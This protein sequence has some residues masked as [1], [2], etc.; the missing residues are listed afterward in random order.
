LA[1]GDPPPL[2]FILVLV[3]G[4]AK[5]C[6]D[7]KAV[8]GAKVI[9]FSKKNHNLKVETTTNQEGKF[10]ATAILFGAHAQAA[11]ADLTADF[12]GFTIGNFQ[13]FVVT[14]PFIGAFIQLNVCL[15]PAKCACTRLAVAVDPPEV[16]AVGDI[17][18][19][20]DRVKV[21]YFINLPY[22]VT[23][24]CA[25]APGSCSGKINVTVTVVVTQ[26]PSSPVAKI[27]TFSRTC[28]GRCPGGGT[29]RGGVG[30]PFFV[31]GRRE[32]PQG[33][34]RVLPFTVAIT[35]VFTP[36]GCPGA[37]IV[38][39]VNIA[40]GGPPP[41]P[42]PPPPVSLPI[43]LP[44]VPNIWRDPYVAYIESI[45]PLPNALSVNV[46]VGNNG[47]QPA[48]VRLNVTVVFEDG[49]SAV[50]VMDDLVLQPNLESTVPVFVSIS[51]NTWPP[52]SMIAEI[53]PYDPDDDRDNNRA[54]WP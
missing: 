20:Q 25:G 30:I 3:Q 40:G 28:N 8:Q 29:L 34:L 51:A 5:L 38:I 52:S 15:Q 24:T 7:G 10:S 43:P 41:P 16:S 42:P 46:R 27:S 36:V 49:T 22:K 21:N 39:P 44:I 33:V 2:G 11:L 9:L 23:M 13:S 31:E 19:V 14:L 53:V 48:R 32:G 47:T 50:G 6:T 4:Q 12:P 26:A 1:G 35:L 18:I 54:E 37:P 17:G 45:D